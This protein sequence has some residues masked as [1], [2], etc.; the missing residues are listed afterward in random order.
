METER[1]DIYTTCILAVLKSLAVILGSSMKWK[2]EGKIR[3][4]MSS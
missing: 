3:F 4:Q 2:L 1:E